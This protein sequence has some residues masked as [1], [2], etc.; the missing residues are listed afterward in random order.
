MRQRRALLCFCVFLTT[1][2]SR[3]DVVFGYRGC[4]LGPPLRPHLCVP[5]SAPAGAQLS[6]RA[7]RREWRTGRKL[8]LAILVY[9]LCFSFGLTY[10][11]K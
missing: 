3:G 10:R 6:V 9:V 7:K 2:V 1:V 4:V 8:T 5:G 11:S